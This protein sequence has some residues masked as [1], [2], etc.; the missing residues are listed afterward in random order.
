M[1][2]RTKKHKPGNGSALGFQAIL[3]LAADKLR[4]NLDADADRPAALAGQEST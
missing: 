2:R 1:P 3:W 4:N